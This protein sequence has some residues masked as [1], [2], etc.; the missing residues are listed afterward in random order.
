MPAKED[1]SK[2]IGKKYNLLTI[3]KDLGTRKYSHGKCVATF[4]IAECECGKQF[5]VRLHSLRSNQ[6][7]S[8]GCILRQAYR[9][10]G[11]KIKKHFKSKTKDHSRWWDMITRCYNKN[12]TS[13]KHYGGR[14]IC[15]CDE[16]IQS[17]DKFMEDMGPPPTDKHT[18]DRIN[19][20][21]NYCKKNCRWL[22]MKQQSLNRRN[23]KKIEYN[24]QN[25]SLSEWSEK[26]NFNHSVLGKRLKRGWSF[27]KA[28]STPIKNNGY[29]R[30]LSLSQ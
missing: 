17:F 2:E 11:I 18:I 28:I 4:V 14:G 13:F 25:L 15:V 19:V 8:C 27:E 12:S 1:I 3:I 29:K 26:L 21:G 23:T 30:Q 22:T 6:T 20:N 24:G 10:Y 7:I 9:K 5:D 16:W